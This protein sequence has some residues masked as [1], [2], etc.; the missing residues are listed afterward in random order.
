MIGKAGFYDIRVYMAGMTLCA[1]YEYISDCFRLS[2]G[3]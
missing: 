2:S 1:E 3:P